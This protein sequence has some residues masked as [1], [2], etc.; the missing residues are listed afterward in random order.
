[1]DAPDTVVTPREAARL[2]TEEGAAV[3]DGTVVLHTPRFDGDYRAQTGADDWARR[4]VPGSHHIDLLRQWVDRTRSY[5]FSSPRPD[6]LSAELGAA[7]VDGA[8]PV[9]V[10]DS[11]T[12]AWAARLWWTLRNAG[13]PAV[14]LDGGLAAWEGAR[15]PVEAGPVAPPWPTSG[16]EPRD[17]GL[18]ASRQDVETHL[19][20]AAAAGGNGPA[21]LVC[22][23]SIGQFI[24][25]R[26]T[27]YATRR[28]HI[29]GSVNIGARTLVDRES[30]ALL[31]VAVLRTIFAED[32]VSEDLDRPIIVYCGGGIAACLTALGLVRAGHR[33]VRVY[34]GSLEEWAADP[35]RPL[36]SGYPVG[37]AQTP[38][39]PQAGR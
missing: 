13:V 28:G 39:R 1:M 6:E 32:G 30:N 5:H 18:W 17:L 24:G 35:H 4:H 33:A 34:D 16:P 12:G 22:A 27:R 26:T 11:A 19:A 38:P 25:N 23:R 3:F 8:K 37:M 14:V 10:Y 29:P 31:D 7:G 36:V 9:V 15:L 2:I 21:D 20:E